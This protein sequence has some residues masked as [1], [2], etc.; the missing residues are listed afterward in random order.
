[1]D[2]LLKI[3]I[4]N[5]R[6]N[7][8]RT[9]IT[10]LAIFVGVVVM[11]LTRGLVNG[12]Q[13]NLKSSVTEVQLGD[14]QVHAKGYVDSMEGAPLTP[15]L[16]QDFVTA[17]MVAAA[18]GEAV[19]PRINFG[20]MISNGDRS[21]MVLAQSVDPAKEYAVTP[22]KKA[23][24]SEGRAL[25]PGDTG[26]AVLAT[27]LA[28][29][30]DVK[31]GSTITILTNTATGA[32]NATDLVVVGLVAA[33]NALENKRLAVVPLADAQALLKMNGVVTE[34]AVRVPPGKGDDVT[35][36]VQER[37]IRSLAAKGGPETEVHT[38]KQLMPTIDQMMKAQNFVLALI[39]GIIFFIVLVGIINTMLMSVFERVREIGTMMAM[40]MRRPQ[41]ITVFMFEA[42]TLGILGAL[43][44]AVAGILLVMG[45]DA[46]EI[47]LTTP[48]AAVPMPLRTMLDVFFPIKAIIIATISAL[49]AAIYPAW[50]ASK[51]KPIDAIRS[52]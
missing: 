10:I 13:G 15:N 27:G 17:E 12:I 33:G 35:L 2:T 4:R 26:V 48:G 50:Q 14:M 23:V 46:M 21:T 8:R 52:V 30:L 9:L 51:L 32:M 44:G 45:I 18:G 28:K 42:L 25:E 11:L 40:G 7:L 36:Q 34:F 39:I 19:A 16:P 24:I 31:I 41:V 3:G 37:L 47:P 49:I 5:V 6:R 43:F 22:R 38:W 29:A 20:G 1:M